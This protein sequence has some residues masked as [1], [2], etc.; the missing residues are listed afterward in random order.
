MLV[1]CQYDIDR[2]APQLRHDGAEAHEI[3]GQEFARKRE[4]FPQQ[5][6]A[7]KHAAVA[8]EQSLLG[9]ETDLADAMSRGL[10]YHR[11]AEIVQI[12]KV[13]TN[14]A[15]DDLLVERSGILFRSGQIEWKLRQPTAGKPHL[16]LG[17]R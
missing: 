10:D 11:I 2:F 17:S 8:R 9:V 7:A 14:A 3:E 1:E 4:I 15:R 6:G 16:G 12:P 5:F 13:D